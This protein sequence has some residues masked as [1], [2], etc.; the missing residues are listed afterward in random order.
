MT[1][2]THFDAGKVLRSNNRSTQD[3]A[4]ADARWPPRNV[5]ECYAIGIELGRARV[6]VSV[7]ECCSR[8]RQYNRKQ[9]PAHRKD[10]DNEGLFSFEGGSRPCIYYR[11]QNAEPNRALKKWREHSLQ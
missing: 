9:K 3:L 2:A 8:G 6:L 5:S 1:A 4:P 11:Q 7:K 10:A